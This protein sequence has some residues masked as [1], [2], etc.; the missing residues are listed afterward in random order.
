M[1]EAKAKTDGRLERRSQTV[2][3]GVVPYVV[4]VEQFG[5]QY[6]IQVTRR[7]IALQSWLFDTKLAAL[8]AY[9]MARGLLNHVRIAEHQTTG[10]R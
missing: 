10:K 6:R 4:S 8:T 9:S 3:M 2:L 5:S 1:N 7:E